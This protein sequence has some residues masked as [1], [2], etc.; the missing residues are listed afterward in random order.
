VS[1]NA[2]RVGIM[3]R[4]STPLQ[5]LAMPYPGLRPFES[6]DQPLFF[7]REA[8]VEAMLRQL[9]DHRFVAVVGSSGSGKSSLV[10]AG[11]LPAVHEGFIQGSSFW[12]SLVIKP[13][14][15]PYKRLACKIRDAAQAESG[16]KAPGLDVR[17]TAI[18]ETLRRTDCGLLEVLAPANVR[19]DGNVLVVVDQFEELFAFRRPNASRD[20]V[21]S[22]DESAAFVRM[23]LRS[24]SDAKGRLWVVLTMRS[25][26]IGDCEAFLGLPE[27]VSRSQFLVP[28]L[29]REQMEEAICRPG[30]VKEAGFTPF[31]FDVGLINRMINEAG[32]RPDQLPLLQHALMRTWKFARQRAEVSGGPVILTHDD[33]EKKAGGID[34][35]L[36]LH[37]D[38]AWDTIADDHAKANIARR[39]FLL[40][41]DISPDGQI[42]RRRPRVAEIVAVTGSGLAEIQ[43]VVRLFQSDDRN[44]LLPP[45]EED[46]SPET[47]LDVSHEALLRQWRLFASDWLVQE[48]SD[49]DELRSLAKQAKDHVEARGGLLGEQ[50]LERILKWR[51]RISPEWASRYVPR[52][53]WDALLTYI[54]ES[55]NETERQRTEVARQIRARRYL[56]GAVGIVVVLAAIFCAAFAIRAQ[57]E[58]ENARRERSAA[59]VAL[60]QSFVR[61][62]GSGVES[63]GVREALWGLAE[64]PPENQN[65]REEVIR[66]WMKTG[67]SWSRA[68]RGDQLGLHAAVGLNKS[69]Q[70][71]IDSQASEI[72]RVL[73]EALEDP[74]KQSFYELEDLGE[75]LGASTARMNPADITMVADRIAT[76]MEKVNL[77][78][79]DPPDRLVGLGAALASVIPQMNSNA[80][81][82]VAARGASLLVNA[83]M[84]SQANRGWDL[85]HL[86]EALESLTERMNSHDASTITARGVLPLLRPLEIRGKNAPYDLDQVLVAL[87]RQMNPTDAAT[88]AARVATDLEDRRD[89]DDPERLQEL[90]V[91]L[92][93]LAPQ[94]N[95]ID[96]AGMAA[97]LTRAMEASRGQRD[98]PERLSALGTGLAALA[99]RINTDDAAGFANRGALVLEP[100]I[101]GMQ[102]DSRTL[103]TISTAL[104]ALAARMDKKYAAVVATPAALTLT[105]VIEKQHE[106]DSRYYGADVRE[107]LGALA[108][109]LNPNDAATVANRLGKVLEKQRVQSYAVVGAPLTALAARMNPT[110]ATSLFARLS[111]DLEEEREVKYPA[112]TLRSFGEALNALTARMDPADATTIAARLATTLEKQRNTDI[113]Q[114]SALCDAL[115]GL[116]ARMHSDDAT[117]IAVRGALVLAKSLEKVQD[118]ARYSLPDFGMKLS[119][120]GQ[121][122]PKAKQT[123]LA[124]LSLVL[125]RPVPPAPKYGETEYPS[126]LVERTTVAKVAALLTAQELADVLKWPLCVGEAQRLV[127]VELGKRSNREFGGDL[128]TFVQQVDSPGVPGLNRQS[129]DLPAKRP[130]IEDAVKELQ[131][132]IAPAN[133]KQ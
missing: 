125:L 86:S 72:S 114:L 99:A 64:L 78:N 46:L 25:D 39:L 11:L 28:R 77:D 42:T 79:W 94:M 121:D 108:A 51:Q 55:E 103:N 104:A 132:L 24:S 89:V 65:V 2:Q 119:A 102:H 10:R 1:T 17:A 58:A 8:Q 57:R 71:S 112:E 87:G 107:A 50:D 6:E 47:Y 60:V 23:L 109:F 124:A 53:T 63:P 16:A 115:A 3:N 75:A 62:I 43:E 84:N 127:L 96:A 31:T 76:A 21:A 82:A 101:T 118:E 80:A 4:I 35:A 100:W 15:E 110:D 52:T 37:A 122:I 73:L 44:F 117:T 120:L 32:D 131:L 26:F 130:R 18:I 106:G 66:H 36:S 56:W 105:T 67:D 126:A 22:R 27:A 29:D 128:W 68:V 19:P 129:L 38:A 81:S 13:G 30:E 90:G 9:E 92:V 74:K 12:L 85:M 95:P 41:C 20:E 59:V 34:N 33:Y 83:F 5:R 98:F 113:N 14:H 116:A 111:G 69:L 61:P 54:Q 97:R 7:G 70:M 93:S 45:R 49:A 88:L 133:N 48:R 40:L 91:V 123:Q